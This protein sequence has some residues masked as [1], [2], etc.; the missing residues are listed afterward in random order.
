MTAHLLLL[1]LAILCFAAAAVGVKLPKVDL[2]A[3]GLALL[4]VALAV[5]A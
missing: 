2:V 5:T 4:T 1:A 3:A